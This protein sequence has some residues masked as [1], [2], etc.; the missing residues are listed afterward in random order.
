MNKQ[1]NILVVKDLMTTDLFTLYED[2]NL[3]VLQEIM[4]W[5]AIRDV[6]VVNQKDELVGLVTHR[7]FLKVAISRLAGISKAEANDIYSKI[8]IGDIMKRNVT[9][10]QPDTQLSEAASR[11]VENKYGCLPVVKDKKLIG[12]ITEADFVKTFYKWEVKI[13]R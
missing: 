3:K 6:P 4:N 5:R 2:D 11:M 1:G 7:D 8:R 9:T 13:S 10:V 12:I